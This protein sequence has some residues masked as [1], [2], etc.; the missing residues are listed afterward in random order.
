MFTSIMGTR[1]LIALV[2]S[3]KQRI[4]SLLI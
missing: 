4:K 1:T 3:G 2:Y